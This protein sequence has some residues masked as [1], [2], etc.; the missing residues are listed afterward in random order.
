[1]NRSR[2]LLVTSLI[3]TFA[4]ASD[5]GSPALRVGAL[6]PTASMLEP[7]SGQS[8]TLFPMARF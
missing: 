1:M 2:P 6:T 3:V 8:A 5:A 4:S 7:R